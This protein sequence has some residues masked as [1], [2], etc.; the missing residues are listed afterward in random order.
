[1]ATVAVD[2]T[3]RVSGFGNFGR[4]ARVSEESGDAPRNVF[5]EFADTKIARRTL[6]ERQE[7]EIGCFAHTFAGYFQWILQALLAKCKRK[8]RYETS[9]PNFLLN[10]G[11]G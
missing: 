8:F 6:G 2:C 3:G 4:R 10:L 5:G 1:M 9:L 11:F 7:K